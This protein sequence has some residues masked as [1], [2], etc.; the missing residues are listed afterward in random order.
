MREREIVGERE[1]KNMLTKYQLHN[2]LRYNLRHFP[3]TTKIWSTSSNLGKYEEKERAKG[4][5][6]QRE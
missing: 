6:T 1:R 3:D 5:K 2:I 4:R